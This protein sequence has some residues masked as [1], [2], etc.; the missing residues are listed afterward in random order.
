MTSTGNI[1]IINPVVASKGKL[2]K[3]VDEKFVQ[4]TVKGTSQRTEKACS[5][6]KDQE[7]DTF[8]TV[9]DGKTLSEIIPTLPF[10]FQFNRNLKPNDWKD[11][12]KVLQLHQLLKDSF[13]MEHGQ[14]EVQPSIPLGRTW[15]KLPKDMSQRDT[16]QKSYGNH[17][18]MDSNQAVQTPGGEA[19][20]LL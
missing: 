16:L 4:G 7:E 17:Q 15:S 18:R 1:T 20:H 5:E 14:E 8:D 3:A 11:M 9:V 2:A 13:A 19:N 6:P 10:T 12:D